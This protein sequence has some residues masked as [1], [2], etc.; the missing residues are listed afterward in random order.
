[1]HKNYI[2]YVVLEVYAIMCFFLQNSECINKNKNS[3]TRSFGIKY[4][5]V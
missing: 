4:C 3:M 5:R 2:T 1:M